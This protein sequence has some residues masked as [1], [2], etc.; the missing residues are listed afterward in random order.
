MFLPYYSPP[1]SPDP[2]TPPTSNATSS[3]LIRGSQ[4]LALLLQAGAVPS[5]GNALTKQELPG[6]FCLDGSPAA[7]YL[8]RAANPNA[9]W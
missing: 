2:R 5:D 4:A 9:N 6:T 3:S 7:F 8:R 1:E